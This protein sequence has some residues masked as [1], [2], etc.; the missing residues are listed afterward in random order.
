MD[1]MKLNIVFYWFCKNLWFYDNL[2]LCEVIK[3]SGCFFIVYI[4]LFVIFDI[5]I[6]VNRW[7]FLIECLEDLDYSLRSIGF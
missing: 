2:V 4:L 3:G 5:N 6:F 7:N 1:D